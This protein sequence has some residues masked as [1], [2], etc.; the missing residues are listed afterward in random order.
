MEEWDLTMDLFNAR[1]KGP[2]RDWREQKQTNAG[3]NSEVRD[4]ISAW[5]HRSPEIHK[6]MATDLLLYDFALAM[7]KK[8]TAESLSIV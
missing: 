4:K 6:T 7:F 3:V 5:A 2:V 8:Q 1:V